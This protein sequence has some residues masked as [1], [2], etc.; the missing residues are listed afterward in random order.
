MTEDNL[1]EKINQE[2]GE[3]TEVQ[4]KKELEKNLRL[5]KKYISLAAVIILLIIVFFLGY[6]KGQ[7]DVYSENKSVPLGK[8]V[9]ENQLSAKD[10]KVD[11]ALFWKVWDLVKE[12]HVDRNNL[13][14]QKMVYGAINGMLQSTKDP[15]SNFFN[16]EESKMFSQDI[17]GSFDGIGA[18]LGVKDEILTVVA[19]LDGSPAKEAGLRSGDKILKI[20]GKSSLDLTIEEAVEMIRGKRG[21]EVVLNILH[22]GDNEAIDIAITRRKIVVDSVKLEFKE[23]NIAYLK[24]IKFSEDVDTQFDVAL[25]KIITTKSKGIILDLR[26]N[27]GGLLNKSIDIASRMMPKDKIVVSEEDSSGKKND[28]YTS[29]GD[30]LSSI[31][32]VVLINEGSASA[33]E[34]LAGAL[35][36]NQGLTF[37]G[38]KTFGKGCVQQLIDLPG[39]SSVK[40]TVAKWLTPKGEY[41]MDKGIAPDVEVKMTADDYK[42]KLDPQFNKALELIKEKISSAE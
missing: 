34:I 10:G 39:G 24:I 13:D 2:I 11:F 18:E 19:P 14:A 15:Y 35:K 7:N 38:E 40:I 8:A 3:S 5:F 1:K 17:A 32:M 12:K 41:I 16:P 29:G 20:N 36:D 27:P 42:N 31:P 28:L 23:D 6:K 9:V 30:K 37:V 26:D 21:T 4:N 22:D 25:N 33:S